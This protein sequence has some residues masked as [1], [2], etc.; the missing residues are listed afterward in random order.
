MAARQFAFPDFK[1]FIGVVEDV[2]DPKEMGRLQLRVY[3]YHTE[4]KGLIPTEMLPWAT[5]ANGIQSASLS[6]LGH[7][8][9]GVVKGTTVWG[10]FVDGDNAEMP[11]ICGTL[12]GIPKAPDP[13]VGFN[14]PDGVYPDKPGESDVNRLSRGDTSET[15]IEAMRADIDEAR[16]AFGGQWKEP[17]TKYAAKYPFN[18]VHESISGHVHEVDDTEGAER[19][20]RHHKAG[21][22]EEVHPD[23]TVVNKVV[24]DRY[25][26]TMGDDY[27]HI[28]GDC[29][30]HIEGKSSVFINGDAD[31]EIDGNLKETVHGNYEMQVDGSATWKVNGDWRRESDTHIADNAPMIDHN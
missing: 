1:W 28:K 12:P 25:S 8:P 26:L 24:K 2:Q 21:T 31:I 22:F 19:L 13:S 23:G 14:D 11:L 18:H 29:K 4:D 5:V 17:E 9:T 6:G 10:F 16:V 3:G 15:V 20:H 30:V 27:V 7:S